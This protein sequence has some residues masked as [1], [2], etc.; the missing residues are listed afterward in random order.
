MNISTG[1]VCLAL[2]VY[3]E[4]RGENDVVKQAVVQTIENRSDINGSTVC[5][6]TFRKNQLTWTRGT[7]EFKGGN[8][9]SPTFLKKYKIRNKDE[10]E[11][12]IEFVKTR[13]QIKLES[14]HFSTSNPNTSWRKKLKRL[15]K[16]GPFWFYKES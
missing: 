12:S 14:T 10:W 2:V 16:L 8:I 11:E 1:L 4:A 15:V 7:K 9:Y 6:E 5:K 13:K 3:H